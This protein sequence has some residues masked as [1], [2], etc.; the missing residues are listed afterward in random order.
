MT[1]NLNTI[2]TTNSLESQYKNHILV[3]GISSDAV[4]FSVLSY[5]NTCNKQAIICTTFYQQASSKNWNNSGQRQATGCMAGF[6]SWQCKIYSLSTS[7]RQA[8]GT[9]QPPTLCVLAA[10]S[11]GVGQQGP[12]LANHLHLMLK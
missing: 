11:L 2:T 3:C 12:K 9:I 10:L 5:T 6:N 8:L 1:W 7:Y 4:P